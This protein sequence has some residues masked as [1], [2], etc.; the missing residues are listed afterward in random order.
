MEYF[1][2]CGVDAALAPSF[3]HNG[4][5]PCGQMLGYNYFTTFCAFLQGGS[6]MHEQSIYNQLVFSSERSIKY[7]NFIGTFG[8]KE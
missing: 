3:S 4:S 8:V 1:A 5:P 7:L 6:K 2:Y